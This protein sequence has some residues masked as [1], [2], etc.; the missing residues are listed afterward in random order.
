MALGSSLE[1]LNLAEEKAEQAVQEAD[2]EARAT[3]F[4]KLQE[5]IR[6]GVRKVQSLSLQIE[7]ANLE[8]V[9]LDLELRRSGLAGAGGKALNA[10]REIRLSLECVTPP[11]IHGS[12]HSFGGLAQTCRGMLE[13]LKERI[14]SDKNQKEED[15]DRKASSDMTADEKFAEALALEWEWIQR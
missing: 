3:G 6:R 5:A 1:A 14:W 7:E 2:R 15:H 11:P 13:R 12:P 9:E 4:E 8:L 10:H